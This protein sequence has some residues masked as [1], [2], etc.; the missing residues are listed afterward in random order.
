MFLDN[1]KQKARKYRFLFLIIILVGGVGAYW[2]YNNQSTSDTA[3]FYAISKVDKGSVSTDIET[4]G[5]I[6]AAEK[7]DI[8]VYK[9]TSRISSVNVENGGHV[10]A[11][12]VIL[13]FDKNDAYVDAA[14]AA[15]AVNEAKLALSTA[16][17][18]Q[19]DPNSTARTLSQKIADYQETI[20]QTET[21]LNTA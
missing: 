16:Q 12:Q 4:T 17:N 5:T 15:V 14:S 7:I 21:K 13:S 18:N 11:D 6:E 1:L 2:Y 9:Q 8:D 19:S 10:E 20:A 3:Q